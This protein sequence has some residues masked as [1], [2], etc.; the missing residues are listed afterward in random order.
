[1]RPRSGAAKSVR[2]EQEPRRRRVIQP[3]SCSSIFAG[4]QENETGLV[5]EEGLGSRDPRARGGAH[6][7]CRRRPARPRR[8]SPTVPAV[9]PTPMVELACRARGGT[10]LQG[11]RRSSLPWPPVKLAHTTRGEA[12]LQGRRRS[13]LSWHL[14]RCVEYGD[15]WKEERKKRQVVT[16]PLAKTWLSHS[17]VQPTK[18]HHTNSVYLY[19]PYQTR[20]V[21]TVLDNLRLAWLQILAMLELARLPNTPY[22]CPVLCRELLAVPD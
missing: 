2:M 4:F 17:I 7:Q 20:A 6:L 1:M 8:S 5:K 12:H 9:A 11:W 14:R 18:H 22:T 19:S 16:S 10:S 21:C 15:G 13:S 3:P